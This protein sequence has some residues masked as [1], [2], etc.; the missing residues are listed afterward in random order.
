MGKTHFVREIETKRY[1]YD[2]WAYDILI[3]ND[4]ENISISMKNQHYILAFFE[5][6]VILSLIKLY[7][8][9]ISTKTSSF[10]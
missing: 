6:S 9:N 4:D 2:K 7:L 10:F 8:M 5:V 3:S 1:K